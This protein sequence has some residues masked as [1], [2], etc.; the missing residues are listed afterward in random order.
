MGR[1]LHIQML[2]NNEINRERP[3]RALSWSIAERAFL[4]YKMENL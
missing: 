1:I 3:A 2:V 4:E